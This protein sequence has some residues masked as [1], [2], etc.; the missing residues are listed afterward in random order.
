[1]LGVLFLT[2]CGRSGSPA[3][4]MAAGEEEPVTLDWYINF[5]WYSTPWGGNVVSDAITE[6]TGVSIN[7][8]SPIG[9]PEEKFNAL[10]SSDS[11]PDIITLGW[12]E[13]QADEMIEGDMVYALNELADKYDPYFW[14]AADAAA[15]S[16]YTKEDGNL[17]CYPSSSFTPEDYEEHEN[18]GSNQTFLVRKDIYEALGCPDMSTQEGFSDAVKR[19]ARMFPQVDGYP[20]I[21]IGSHEFTNTGCVSFDQYLQNFLAVPCEKDGKFYDRYT[22]PEYI[23]WLKTFRELGQEGYLTNDIFIDQRTQMEEKLAR[24]QYF[25]MIYQ[26]TDM[27][28]LQ[29]ELY[30]KNLDRIYMAVDGPKNTAG[31]DPVLPGGGINGWTVTFISKDCASPDRAIKLFSYLISEEGQ[32]MVYLGVEGVTYDMVDGK[33][34]IKK[35]VQELL[36]SNR[37][38]MMPSMGLTMH[39]GCFRIMSLSLNGGSLPYLLMDN[40]RNGPFPTPTIWPSMICVLTGTARWER[41]ISISRNCGARLCQGSCWRLRRR[42]LTKFWRS[43]WRKGRNLDLRLSWRKAQDRCGRLR[44]NFPYSKCVIVCRLAAAWGFV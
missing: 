18:L 31:D 25:C 38:S 27:T 9:N 32:K 33:P 24:G 40:W 28:G 7:F 34:V 17:Y 37:G 11:L 10:L 22:D 43:L 23:G 21:P 5:T 15:V 41:L 1:M 8:L 20:L 36:S 2:A 19:A 35:E 12:W 13:N 26:R 14:E 44:K 3:G 29:S 16:W 30:T 6:K 39:T 42:N 4:D